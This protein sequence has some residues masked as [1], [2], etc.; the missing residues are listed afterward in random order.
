MLQYVEA[1]IPTQAAAIDLSTTDAVVECQAIYC[2]GTGDIKVDITEPRS[3]A[4]GAAPAVSTVTF[5]T[6]QVGWTIYG[7]FTKVYRTGT[8]ATN[9]VWQR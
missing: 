8:T 5:K 2:G 6:V 9:L 3:G 4:A 7:N 1:F